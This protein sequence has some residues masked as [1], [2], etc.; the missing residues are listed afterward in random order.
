MNFQIQEA[1]RV[2]RQ[3]LFALS[4]VLLA[5]GST[6]AFAQSGD[7]ADDETVDEITV[8]G[9]QI[10]G[11]RISDAL[12]VTVI[13]SRDIEILGIESGD[14]LLDLIPENGQNFFSEADTA[15]GVNAARG[16]VGAFNL[17][18]LGTGNTLVLLNGRRLVNAATYQTE[19]VGG[20]F[21]P[22]NSVNSNHIPVYGLERVEVLRDGASAIYGAD[23][24][25][26]VV[27]T[28]LK[29][30]FEG[31][32]VRLRYSDYDN[33]P[34][35][36]EALSLEW[37]K[38]FN[39]GATRVGVF[40][41][42][43]QRDRV[44]T[45][46]DPRWANSDFRWRFDP[47]SPYATSTR[48]RNNSSNSLWGQFDV[49]SGLSSS[50]SLRQNDVTDSSGE[51]EIYP[52]GDSR[53]SG[54]FDLGYGTCL[55]ED[56]QG[57]V[58][59]NLN[60]NRDLVSEM[61]RTTV[62]GYFDHEMDS[63]LEMFGDFYYYASK[64]NRFNSP[65]TDLS[66]VTLRV[67]AANYYNPLGPAGSPNRLPDSVIG[68]DVPAG[69]LELRMDLYR[70]A[71]FPRIVDNDGE[72]YRFLYGLR[73]TAG[74]WD[75][76]SA[77]T[78]SEATRDE[79][80][81][82][83]LSNTLI[84]EALFDP[85][86]AAY[87][88]FSGGID[89]NVER[90]LI[91]VYRNGESKLSMFDVKF[92][93]P[94]LFELPAGPAAFLAGFEYRRE[95]YIDDRDPRLDGTIT[96]T[97]FEGDTYPLTSDV[98]GS[99]PTPDGKG[100]RTTNS[101]F[102]ELQ[103]PVFDTLDVQL[104][105]RYEDFDDIGDTTVGKV[106]FGWRPVEQ[107]LFRGSWSEAFRAPN[108]ITINEAFVARSNTLNDWGCFYAVDQGT[109]DEDN[110]FSDCDYGIQR[111]ATGSKDLRPEQSTNTS[112]GIVVEPVE[113]LTVTLD[114]WNIEKEDT[115]GLF[116]EENH[117]L[118]DLVL[119]L[120]A[121]TS[122]CASVQGNPAVVRGDITDDPAEQQGF[123]DAG[124]CPLGSVD[125]VEDKYA[126]LDTRTL[127]GYDLGIYYDFETPVGDFYLRYNGAFYKK[128][129]QTASGELST[130]VLAAQEANPAIVY[131]LIGLGDLL[132]I[133][134]NQESRHS[135]SVSWNKGDWAASVSGY[136]ISRFDQILADSTAFNIPSM[137]TYNVKVDYSFAVGDTDMRFRLGVNNAADERAPIADK[138]YGFFPDA[139]RDWG[140]YYYVDV[141]ISL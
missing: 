81:H 124:L 80:T 29:R 115:I 63:G 19:E 1:G 24:V 52:V 11:A 14:E 138:S 58:R 5:L 99:S 70:F 25:A 90:A 46:D 28:V 53:C 4:A 33:L 8:T 66:S 18:N 40:A 60:D 42:Q 51:F 78:V 137:T 6:N 54:G 97:D 22:V 62:Y 64:T 139:H 130:T 50:H 102:T 34:R 120:A 100:S 87:N 89:T 71:E 16:D 104:A 127:R 36:D 61:E 72:S 69:G 35:N 56:G 74:D 133:D 79:V 9:T 57:T 39:N 114:F 21:V 86:P 30:D 116:G 98:V 75:W 85:T 38:T 45:Q 111:Q 59:Y 13:G 67:G 134:G 95:S 10:K 23:A 77:V 110:S 7:D 94:E 68:T 31:L 136:R 103:F 41:R 109:L 26:G 83:R 15:G 49:V 93:N 113:N 128:F 43:L 118:Y 20:S 48:F 76:E 108:L 131:P 105:L 55:H 84:T 121:G 65:S 112:I 92:W 123:L 119:R 82:N 135:A 12:A 132:G 88:P 47:S 44:N 37:G 117:I 129:E 101:L 106:A 73:G 125:Y 107:V 91:D 96:F 141:K 27:N 122:N 126:N 17:R 3:R 2:Y 32:T 140:R